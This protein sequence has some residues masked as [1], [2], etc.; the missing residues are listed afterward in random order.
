MTDLDRL[1]K[2]ISETGIEQIPGKIVS[3]AVK[4]LEITNELTEETNNMIADITQELCCYLSSE[5]IKSTDIER[6]HENLLSANEDLESL[7]RIEKVA[8]ELINVAEAR[9]EEITPDISE[10]DEL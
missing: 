6:I 3:A 5:D 2:I 4:V 1:E 7:S 9:K 10:Q 8:L